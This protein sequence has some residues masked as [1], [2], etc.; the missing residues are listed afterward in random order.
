MT[1]PKSKLHGGPYFAPLGD[2]AGHRDPALDDGHHAVRR[3][4][5]G[6]VDQ[7]RGRERLEEVERVLA[8]LAGAEGELGQPD[9]ERDRRVLDQVHRLAGERRDDDP[10]RHRQQHVAVDLRLASGPARARR[11]RWPRGSDWMPARTCSAIRAEVKKPEAEHRR[12]EL[13]VRG[14][15]AITHAFSAWAGTPARRSTRGTSARAAGCCGRARP[16][17]CRG[18][19][20]RRGASCAAC[21]SPS[22]GPARSPRRRRR[23]RAS[24][25]GRTRAAPSTQHRPPALSCRKIPQFIAIPSGGM[26]RLRRR[27]RRQPVHRGRAHQR[28]LLPRRDNCRRPPA[29]RRQRVG[30]PASD[31]LVVRVGEGFLDR[32]RHREVHVDALGRDRVL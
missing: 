19:R 9:G 5:D 3:H 7:R 2:V 8:D 23:R 29:A 4:R 6:D 27:P 28:P 16:R 26:L 14:I 11:S 17:R 22:P 1:V 32:R 24:T 12:D 10:E 18:G 30:R 20:P 13:R 31:A 21:R 15:R 25:R